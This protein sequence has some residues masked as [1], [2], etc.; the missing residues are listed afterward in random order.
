MSKMNSRNGLLL[1]FAN[2]Q[3]SCVHDTLHNNAIGVRLQHPH[4]LR[5]ASDCN[6]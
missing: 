4:S 3:A 5:V 1:D 6:R 2:D